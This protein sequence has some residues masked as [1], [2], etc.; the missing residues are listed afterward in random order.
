MAT[1]AI[2]GPTAV[3][4]SR[5]ALE[6]ALELGGEIVSV[7]SRQ[8]YKHIYIGTAKP[9]T[10]DRALIPHHMIDILELHERNNAKKYAAMAG[11][12]MSEIQDRGKLPFLV[13]GSGLYFRSI[14]KGLFQVDLEPSKREAF[15]ASVDDIPTGELCRRL[16]EADPGSHARIHPNDRYRIVRALEVYELTGSPLSDHYKQQVERGVVDDTRFIKIG[17]EIPRK[18]LIERIQE[19]TVH[20]IE[21]GWIEEVRSLLDGGANPEWPGMKT[22]GYPESISFIRGEI[23]R[24]EMIETISRQTGQYAKRQMTWFRKEEGIEWYNPLDSSTV[25]AVLKLIT[26][27]LDGHSPVFPGNSL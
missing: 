9:S 23:T 17:L 22:L 4:K 16:S 13:G 20:M 25:Q 24:D 18:L 2:M 26:S 1:V 3:G 27:R 5:L 10:D 6:L 11:K 12:T 15:A 21:S 19:R 8:A 7:D 14:F